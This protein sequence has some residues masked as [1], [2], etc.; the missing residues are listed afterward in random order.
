MPRKGRL[1]HHHPSTQPALGLLGPSGC[2]NPP[3]DRPGFSGS[4]GLARGRPPIC[5]G[6]WRNPYSRPV[7]WSGCSSWSLGVSLSPRWRGIPLPPPNVRG[8]N[9]GKAENPRLGMVK[10]RKG[11][12]GWGVVRWG[13]KM[14]REG[15]KARSLRCRRPRDQEVWVFVLP[16]LMAPRLHIN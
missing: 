10:E 2:H 14:L 6:Y 13:G 9:G 4:F 7:V 5:T 11:A 12:V 3:S 1:I 8:A 15:R 16:P